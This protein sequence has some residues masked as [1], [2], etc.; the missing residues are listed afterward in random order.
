MTIH[1]PIKIASFSRKTSLLLGLLFAALFVC[2]YAHPAHAW[3]IDT[4]WF[5]LTQSSGAYSDPVGDAAGARDIVG[6]STTIPGACAA[7]SCPSAS[8]FNDGTYLYFRIR[9]NTDPRGGGGLSPFGWGLLIDTNGILTDYEWMIMVNGIN[10]P[11]Q[12][13]IDRNVVQGVIDDPSDKAEVVG[14]YETAVENANYRVQLADSTFDSNPDYFLDFRV[15]YATFKAITGITDSTPIK[16]YVGSSNNAQVLSADLGDPS[17]SVG[18]SDPVLPVGTQPTTGSV[19]FVSDLTGT[20]DVTQ[21]YQG[22]TLYVKVTD[23]DRNTSS[24]TIQTVTVVVTTQG[25]DSETVIL[26]ET[27]GNSGVFTG[28]I[29]TAGGAPIPADTMLQVAPIETVTVTYVDAIDANLNTDQPRTDTVTILASADLSVTKTASNTTPSE[30]TVLDYTLTVTNNGPNTVAGIQVTDVLP[31]GVKYESDSGAGAYNKTTGIWEVPSLVS[32]ASSTLVISVSVRNGTNGTTITNT[33]S[34]TA[35]SLPDPVSGNNTASRPITVGGADLALSK[36]VSTPT[37]TT[38]SSITYTVAVSN[39]GANNATGVQVTDLLPAGTSYTSHVVTQGTY[40]AASGVWTVG[41]LATGTTS[42]LAITASVTAAAG[43]T[44]TNTASVT[45]SDQADGI[46]A[47]NSASADIYV[48]GADLSLAKTVSNASP[49][50]GASIAYRVVATNNGPGS[51]AGVQVTDLLPAGLTFASAVASQGTYSSG[52]GIWTIGALATS[53]TLTINATVNSGTNGQT[54]T[55]TAAITASSVGDPVTANNTA[56]ASLTVQRADVSL[57]K[58]VSTS[59]PTLGASLYYLVAAKNNGPN[60][61]TNLQ[62]TDVLPALVTFSSYTVT[63]PGSTYTAGT[64]LWNI[65]TLASGATTT[66][67]INVTVSNNNNDA[68]KT[69]VNTATRTAADQADPVSANNTAT[70]SFTIEGCDLAVAKTVDNS[71]PNQSGTVVFTVTIRNNGPFATGKNVEVYDLLPSGLSYVSSAV[72]EGS[73]NQASGTWGFGNTTIATGV[74]HT[75]TLTATV[76]APT[77]STVIN[78]AN[79][80]TLYDFDLSNNLASVPI[81]VGGTDISVTKAV[82]DASPNAGSAITYTV[83]ARNNGPNNAT[84]L[85]ILDVLAS[86]LTY[87]LS[88]ATTGTYDSGTGQ[89]TIPA[90][91]TGSTATLTI[92][93]V[94]DAGTG[95]TTINNTATIT[96]M[97]EP[98][99]NTANDSASASLTVQAADLAVTKTASTLTPY[100]LDPVVYTITVTNNGP[101]DATNVVVLDVLST[102]LT[103]SSHVVSQG[104]YSVTTGIW[105][106]G[107]VE[108]LTPKTLQI[109]VRPNLLTGGA[110]IVNTAA[111]SA[112]D[113]EDPAP[114]NNSANI[115]ITP[116]TR[117]APTIVTQKTV[118]VTSD[119]I[120]TAP[121]YRAIPGAVMEYTVYVTNQGS[122]DAGTVSL[123]DPI[124]PGTELFVGDL[125]LPGSGPVAFTDGST[126]SGLS[127]PGPANLSFSDTIGGPP[128]TYGYVPAAGGFDSTVTSMR[129]DLD[130]AFTHSAGAPYPSFTV[131][132]RV[133]VR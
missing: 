106:V 19:L 47:N 119:P 26:T 31:G 50:E 64:G 110:N 4:E 7:S 86:G 125:G 76:T 117:P 94:V 99:L 133:R 65:G 91:S 3:P 18:L 68:L 42:T 1:S 55:N 104:T 107:T 116:V 74:T 131:R 123:E 71:T 121:P 126:A 82:S 32:G 21:A 130:G 16:L 15:S 103:Y 124:A 34:V 52:T 23:G 95:G 111:V 129:I 20:G 27:S 60:A 85:T 22:Q 13:E 97:T 5:P 40:T 120:N 49:N 54:L 28:S 90:L 9:L 58:L 53:A 48:A 93:A 122:G 37:P 57:S 25:G 113:Q 80:A 11:D 62:V 24:A 44:V 132:F 92:T 84:A 59:S 69:V 39:N 51:P 43:T 73:Y 81:H 88:S 29:M 38:G 118:A 2:L 108:K 41:S 98:D 45:A 102:D 96:T 127:Y 114:A 78:S 70:A 46:A 115:T 79:N 109:T 61:A 8:L 128:Y 83:A 67:R 87:S 75:L 17:L 72:T 63:P 77:G 112:A 6:S 89:W 10:N 33:A 36:T 30:G 56:S 35:A 105:D 66:L 14:W 100:E 12:I 101:D